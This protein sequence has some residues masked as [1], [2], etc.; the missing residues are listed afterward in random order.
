MEDFESF[1]YNLD[2]K[3]RDSLLKV[4]IDWENRA[5]MRRVVRFEPVRINVLEKL[6][7]LKFIDPEERHN[8]APSIQLFYEF[9]RK[10]QS[11]FVYGYVVSPFRND[12]RVS[13]EGMTVIE[14]DI[15]ECLKKDFFEFN[16]TASEIKTDSGLVSWWD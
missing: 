14:E 11:V 1:K 12:Y 7:E 8:D 3:T 16:K 5:L 2:Y 4:E 6:M 13:I 15:T 9:L 10:H